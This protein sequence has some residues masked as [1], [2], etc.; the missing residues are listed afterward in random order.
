VANRLATEQSPYLLQHKDNPVDW[1]PWGSEAF[2][3]AR[4][5]NMIAARPAMRADPTSALRYE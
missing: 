5:E 4:R 2:D 3:A 1:R